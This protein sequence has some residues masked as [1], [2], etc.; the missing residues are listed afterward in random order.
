MGTSGTAIFEDDVAADVRDQFLDLLRLGKSAEEATEIVAEDWSSSIDDEDDGPIYWL[1]LSATQWKYGCLQ[2]NVLEKALVVIDSGAALPR[3]EGAAAKR[4]KAALEK[5]KLT[6]QSPQPPFKRPRRK[7]FTP[8]AIKKVLAPDQRASASA[9]EYAPTVGG[10]P[11]WAQVMVEVEVQ[12]SVGGS[13]LG[14]VRC[15]Y[16]EVEFEWLSRDSLRISIPNEA[17][18]AIREMPVRYFERII[19][20]EYTAK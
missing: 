18:P 17:V 7:P 3:W 8:P 10:E 9:S 1:A 6:L 14:V 20:V 13:G 2:R 5:L 15:R 16:N 19:S 11:C 12:G 4:R